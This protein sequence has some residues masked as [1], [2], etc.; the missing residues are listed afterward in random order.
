MV[1]VLW[2][3]IKRSFDFFACLSQLSYVLF[4]VQGL[5]LFRSL[6]S[7][8]PSSSLNAFTFA[9]AFAAAFSPSLTF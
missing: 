1:C 9:F 5:L 2:G 4:V 7:S 3:F 6:P 8:L